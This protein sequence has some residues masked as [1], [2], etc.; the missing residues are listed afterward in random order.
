MDVFCCKT[1]FRLLKYR[2]QKSTYDAP[3]CPV[4]DKMSLELHY[5][6]KTCT[7]AEF[8]GMPLIS[9]TNSTKLCLPC[10]SQTHTNN[11]PISLI[12]EQASS[13]Q[14]ESQRALSCLRLSIHSLFS[15]WSQYE[16]E[17]V[18]PLRCYRTFGLIPPSTHLLIVE[19]SSRKIP[20]QRQ[21]QKGGDHSTK[22]F[23]YYHHL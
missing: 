7:T 12:I 1:I 5:H 8:L 17:R 14:S 20:L 6:L 13:H 23:L 15:P 3:Y 22:S 21:C 16:Q 9:I 19:N 11:L 10:V 2:S 18:R 4:Y